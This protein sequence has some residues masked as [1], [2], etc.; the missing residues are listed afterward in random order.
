V[1]LSSDHQVGV[2]RPRR[3]LTHAEAAPGWSSC[4]VS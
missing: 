1:F 2:A 4:H 3:A